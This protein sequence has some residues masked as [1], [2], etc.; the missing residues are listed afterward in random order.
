[1]ASFQLNR[2]TQNI[3]GN[4]TFIPIQMYTK[5]KVIVL[6]FKA[7]VEKKLGSLLGS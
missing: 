6:M 1:M 3:S 4:S 7:L 2:F 5:R